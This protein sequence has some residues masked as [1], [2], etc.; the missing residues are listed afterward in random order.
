MTERRYYKR[1]LPW[2]IMYLTM[3]YEK[4][5]HS[6]IANHLKRKVDSIRSKADELGIQLSKEEVEKRRRKGF[7]KY[8]EERKVK[9]IFKG[10][11]INSIVFLSYL[12]K[13]KYYK[14]RIL[15]LET[16]WN[17][18]CESMGVDPVFARS[19]SRKR[20]FSFCRQIFCYII[21]RNYGNKYS[22]DDIA[23]FIGREDH[24]T[25]MHG[26]KVIRDGIK[27]KDPQFL[28]EWYL[29]LSKTKIYKA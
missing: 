24:T 9:R 26:I 29:F 8:L 12:E 28:K 4:L 2:E 17:D 13:Q 3:N 16:V 22:L 27:S 1:W 14:T 21:K 7:E 23:S 18:I 19:K 15:P 20:E 25:A 5:D 11:N 10:Y 6:E